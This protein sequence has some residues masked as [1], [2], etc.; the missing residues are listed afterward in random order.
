VQCMFSM[1]V[2]IKE[3]NETEL[4][5]LIKALELS[6]TREEFIG[7]SIIIESD[8]ANAIDWMSNESNTPWRNC[9]SSSYLPLDFL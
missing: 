7:K 9:I 3:S 2:G 6:S 8:S 1:S 5:E 4:L